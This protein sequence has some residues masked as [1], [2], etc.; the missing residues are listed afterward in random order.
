MKTLTVEKAEGGQSCVTDAPR[1]KY[2]SNSTSIKA[3]HTE[4]I[5]PPDT[6]AATEQIQKSLRDHCCKFISREGRRAFQGW[7]IFPFPKNV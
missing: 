6:T 4:K 3:K 7:I 1:K 2:G 5:L